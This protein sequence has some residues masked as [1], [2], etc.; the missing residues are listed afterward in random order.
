MA[1]TCALIAPVQPI[2]TEFRVVMKHCQMHPNTTRHTQTWV[3]GPMGLIR[4][5]HC[6][7]F[8][9]D[10]M[11]RT[12]AWIAPVQPILHRV[13]CSNKILPNT[14]KHYETHTNMSLGS[15]GVDWV[16]SLR[17]FWCDF[18]ARTSALIAPVQPVL[19]RVSCSNETLT[20][21]PKHYENGPKHEFRVQWGGS[22]AFV[23]QKFR[24]KFVARTFALIAL[25]QPVLHR[26]SCSNEILPNTPKH[27]ET[28]TNMSLWSNGV[29]WVRSLWK[30]LM[31]LHGT[32]FYINCTSSTRFAPSFV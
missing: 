27:Y 5:V 14:H 9:C 16:R 6:E 22:R 2:C 19:H 11:A 18:M 7:K 30:I 21:T 20:N 13:S 28:L 26:V 32:N 25:V 31:R 23:A 1:Q 29:D 24:C 17:K 12:C 10:F 8:R 3:Y 4:S 15:N